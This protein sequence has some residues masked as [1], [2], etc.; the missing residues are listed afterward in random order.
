MSPYRIAGL[1]AVGIT[2]AS[3]AIVGPPGHWGRDAGAIGVALAQPAAA[4]PFTVTGVAV[5]VT[6][7]TA[8]EARD[9]AFSEGARVALAQLIEGLAGVIPTVDAASLPAEE[10]GALIQAFEVEEERT[11]PGR[12]RGTLTYIFREDAIRALLGPDVAGLPDSAA[13]IRPAPPVLI[14][15]V[16][17]DFDSVRLWDSPNPWHEAWLD[18][19][20]G[21]NAVPVIVPF[22][23]LADVLDVDVDRAIAGDADALTAIRNR[24]EAASTVV[25][26]VEP[27]GRS[28][29]VRLERYG[30]V[31]DLGITTITMAN[32]QAL[33]S[34]LAAAVGRVAERLA[35][36]WR[37]IAA[38]PT[39]PTNAMLVL[40]PLESNRDWFRI[41]SR[42]QAIPALVDTDVAS[43]SPQEAVIEL[44]YRGEEQDFLVALR[45]QGLTLNQGPVALELRL[46]QE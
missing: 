31:E 11:S 5:D 32:E 20:A 34:A 37:Q 1:A 35:A 26:I 3:W 14:L 2:A 12:Y 28:V 33:P 10:I 17:Q 6:A 36:D 38:V 13:P 18:Y 22:G 7:A 21:P 4:E 44:A 42:L 40:V 27:T 8:S 25:A 43:L 16:L 30:A 9:Q 19:E 29:T 23:D 41:R 45:R 24:Y 46:S 15:P 39:G